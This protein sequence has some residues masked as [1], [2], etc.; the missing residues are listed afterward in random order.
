MRA[1]AFLGPVQAVDRPL[2]RYRRHGSNDSEFGVSAAG[3]GLVLRRK[4]SY[5]RNEIEAVKELAR[6]HGL[7]AASDVGERAGHHLFLRLSSLTVDPEHH[8]V[9]G[10][11]RLRLLPRLLVSQWQASAPAVRRVLAIGL[12]TAAVVL[13]RALGWRLLAWWLA[14]AA[15]P[16]WLNRIASWRHRTRTR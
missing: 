16:R 10:D 1:I 3:L 6:D 12:T 8:P 5:A 4:I 14:P 13:P 2:G 9:P 7:E 15:R 11:S